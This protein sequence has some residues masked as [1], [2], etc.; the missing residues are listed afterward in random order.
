MSEGT[1]IYVALLDEGVDVWRPVRAMH[2][3]GNIFLIIDESY[4]RESESWQFEPGEKV[5]C[6]EIASDQG[7]I[8]AA[9]RR[10]DASDE[11]S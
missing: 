11:R 8:L 9:I 4:D 7:T 1:R 6:E 5:V 3:R 2:L 10:A